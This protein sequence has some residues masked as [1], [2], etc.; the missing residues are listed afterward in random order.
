MKSLWR[1][2]FFYMGFHEK[3]KKII[4]IKKT[5]NQQLTKVG[6]PISWRIATKI[7]PQG[8]GTMNMS[9]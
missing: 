4:L 3:K 9:W 6:V 5:K 7:G 8:T 2:K 1:D